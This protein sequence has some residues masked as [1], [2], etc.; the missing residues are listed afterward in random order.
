MQLTTVPVDIEPE[1]SARATELGIDD[2]VRSVLEFTKNSV[3][4][5]H[6]IDVRTWEDHYEGTGKHLEIIA[7][8]DAPPDLRDPD[9]MSWIR[10]VLAMS[11]AT[12]RMWVSCEMY[13]R[14]VAW[15]GR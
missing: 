4:L 8:K 10:A 15:N 13:P 6:S 9:R 5:I 11:S 1:A 14:E 7:W 12:F 2:E 3:P